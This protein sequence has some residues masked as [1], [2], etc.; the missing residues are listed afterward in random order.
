MKM[1]VTPIVIGEHGT[2]PKGLVKG[3]EDLEI[4]EVENIQTTRLS[5]SQQK[6]RTKQIENFT[7]PAD[8]SIKLKN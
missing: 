7:D 4:R 6:K 1:T 2:I 5:D 3:L 8:Y